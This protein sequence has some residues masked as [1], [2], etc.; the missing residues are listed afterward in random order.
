[1]PIDIESI[2]GKI[3][4]EGESVGILDKEN[5]RQFLIKELNGDDLINY[6]VIRATLGKDREGLL[7]YLLTSSK[8]VKI[9]I[10]KEKVQS[11][12]SY[13]KEITGVSRTL[14]SNPAG[15]NAQITVEFPQGS[16]GLRY[17]TTATEIDPFFQ[18]VDEA[19]R[20][21]KVSTNGK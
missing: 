14:L 8:I 9:E 4:S 12:S 13:L 21:I 7:V 15:N 18:K 5:Y 11:L 16:F 20:K 3:L 19:V 1:M 17:P 2:L 10:D 6:L